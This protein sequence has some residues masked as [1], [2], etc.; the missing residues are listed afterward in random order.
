[1]EFILVE[2]VYVP[3]TNALLNYPELLEG[4]QVAILETVLAELSVLEHKKDAKNLQYRLRQAKHTIKKAMEAGTTVVRLNSDL[5]A[6]E[7]RYTND[8]KILDEFEK[9]AQ[10]YPKESIVLVTDDILM[11]VKAKAM[12]IKC[13]GTGRVDDTTE[14]KV[15]GVYEFFYDPENPEDVE[16]LD[17]IT[18]VAYSGLDMYY[19]PFDLVVNQYVVVWDLSTRELNKD[20][21]VS[22]RECGTYKFDGINLKR[23]QF[24]NINNIFEKVKPV[25]VRQRLAFDLLQD[26]KTT[27]KLLTGTFGTGKDYLMLAHALDLVTNSKTKFDKIVWVRNNIEV[28]DTNG[29]GFLP[30]GME[31]K[32]R[33]F[34]APIL[35]KVGGEEGYEM[36]KDKISIEHL[37]FLRGRQ[38]DNAI[39]YVTECQANTRDHIKLLLGRV[40]TE[41]EIWFNGDVKQTDDRKF[42]YDN[43]INALMDL[44]GSPL[45][46]H[47]TL[48]K[49]ER[50]A[51]A[52]LA[53]LLDL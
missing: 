38:F 11:N 7:M 10:F 53:S 39:I 29:I 40:G 26:E 30:D 42:E 23:V 8:D 1:M 13:V 21:E 14:D 2:T 6:Y 9:L 31:D 37:G 27:V 3:D 24:K 17:K 50:S 25:N 49:V 28:K 47:V 52:N 16:I 15:E 51:T 12:N 32:L 22:Y 33:P 43:G 18:E 19:N 34:T 45:F 46:G 36:V 5:D 44:T 4:N 48:D 41:S 20:G 35:D